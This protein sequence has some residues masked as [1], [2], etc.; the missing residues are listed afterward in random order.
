[1]L[2]AV[3]ASQCAEGIPQAVPGRSFSTY[4]RELGGDAIVRRNDE[5]TL[6]DIDTLAPSHIIL[7]PGPCSPAEF[8]LHELYGAEE[9][10]LTSSLRGLAPLVRVDARALGRG[11]R[12]A[13]TRQLAAAYAALVAQERGRRSGK[14]EVGSRKPRP[15]TASAD[16]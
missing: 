7:S 11:T 13:L 8:G 9:A 1:M 3:A 5:L 10:F 2:L 4:I 14:S 6:S 15:K 12:G 16:A